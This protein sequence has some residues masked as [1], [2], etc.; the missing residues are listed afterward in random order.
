MSDP[1][2][3]RVLLGFLEDP[4]WFVRL[5]MVRAMAKAKFLPQVDA[6]AARLTDRSWMVREAAVHTLQQLGRLD[7]LTQAFLGTADRYGREQIADE[8][9][10]AGVIP[11]L[12]FKYAKDSEGAEKQVVSQ[13]ANMGKTSYMLA[14]VHY[15]TDRELR[16][17]FL[18]DFGRHPD[19]QIQ[20][21]VAELAEV[22][23]DPELRALAQ[24]SVL[25]ERG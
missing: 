20:A 8:W 1:R 7:Q 25:P 11:S 9:Q 22:E 2:A 21:W 6:I 24:A 10:R 14:V 18:Q 3:T 15:S 12:L 4:Q 5:H 17:K 13:L 19:M 23:R 16:K